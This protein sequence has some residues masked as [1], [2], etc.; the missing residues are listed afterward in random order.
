MSQEIYTPSNESKH[1]DRSNKITLSISESLETNI[2][3]LN[4]LFTNCTDVVKREV[5]IGTKFPVK[6]YG[7]YVDGLVNREIIESFFLGR[8]IDY[9]N[10][11]ESTTPIEGSITE[12]IIDHFSATFD[13]REVRSM[14]DMVRGILSGDAAIFVEN[15]N[16][17]LMIACRGWPARGVGPPETES[18]IRGP[19]E[20]FVETIRFNTA[21]IRRRI[22]DTKLKVEMTSMGII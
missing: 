12:L 21:L 14:D 20:G 22:R 4:D 19:R 6:I 11:S 13:I 16:V 1:H 3:N 2:K 17:G 9:K 18:V 7:T 10:L 15:T 5:D 8:I